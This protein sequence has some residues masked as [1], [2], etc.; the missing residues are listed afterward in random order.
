MNTKLKYWLMAARPRT[1]PAGASPVI[2][3]TA[4]AEENGLNVPVAL[5]TLACCLLLQTG[6]NIANDYFDSIHGVDGADRLGPAR[7]TQKGLIAP[8]KVRNAFLAC[9]GAAFVL[10]VFLALRGGLP[11]VMVGLSSIAAAYLYTGGP[12]PLSYLGL[13]EILAFVFFGP[14]AVLGTF[15]LQALE[16]SW[17]ALWVGMGPGF[18]SA[19]LMSI[20]NLRDSASDRA[21]GKRTVALMLGVENARR[22]SLG[23]LAAALLVP[24]VYAAFFP[25]N[26]PVLAAPLSSLAFF[27]HWR[28]IA[29]G[30]IDGNLNLSLG[31]TGKYMFVYSIL[32]SA[33]VLL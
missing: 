26:W 28:R 15:Y 16:F 23:L 13:G 27:R 6:S 14:I 4:V 31:A 9:F 3:G 1:L 32:F 5:A 20:N 10:G 8:K 18:L 33:G 29:L 12:K 30:P 21:T 17:K 7:V 22:L 25:K 19:L 2:L 24:L 11:I